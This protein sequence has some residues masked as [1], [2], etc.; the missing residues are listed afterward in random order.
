MDLEKLSLR[1]RA[2]KERGVSDL[3]HQN[4]RMWNTGAA[5]YDVV[6]EDAIRIICVSLA[7]ARTR[8]VRNVLDFG[9]GYGR[10]ARHLRSF[11]P[12]EALYVCDLNAEGV[13][14]CA[15]TFSAREVAENDLPVGLDVI[16]VGSV[17]T[18]LPFERGAHLF[19][20]LFGALASHGVLIATFNGRRATVMHQRTPYIA[21][22]K[23][24]E[25]LRGYDETGAGFVSY[26]LADLAHLGEYGIS[27]TSPAKILSLTERA[28]DARVLSFYEGGWANHQDVAV[29]TR[30][31][32]NS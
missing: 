3:R 22:A 29:W 6:G 13:R 17:F 19:D 31:N 25:V 8:D 9:C 30:D 18:H 4:D 14:F 28:S 21:Q 20:V 1:W 16:W 5:W 24:D 15:E 23:W 12:D 2:Y 32:V 27:L 10:V 11:F 26:G 7:A